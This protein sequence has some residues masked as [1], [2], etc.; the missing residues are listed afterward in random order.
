MIARRRPGDGP[1]RR[2]C[3]V[4][5][6]AG[7]L[8]VLSPLLALTASAVLVV[9]GR[10]V[11][12]RQQ[13]CGRGGGEFTILK[14]RTLRAAERPDQPDAERTTRLGAVLR[15]TGTDELPQ[16]VNVLRGEMSFIGPRPALPEH[17][18]NYDRRQTGRLAVRP[19]I[20]GW[21]QVR[22]RNALSWP[23]RIELDL[24]YI[25]RRGLLLDLRILMLTAVVVLVPRG[26]V[27]PGGV[28]RG[29]P[30]PGEDSGP[31]D[32]HRA[33]RH[34]ADLRDGWT[35]AAPGGADIARH[36]R[37]DEPAVR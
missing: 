15:A 34:R 9:L 4:F 26:V 22:G 33:G 37:D 8:L 35:P 3:D 13:R 20:T 2:V 5:G 16:L 12:F 28:N 10:P 30:A 17:V 21:A 19:G 27:G 36:R 29:M 11:S 31:R 24:D 7:L 25:R 23:E 6:A 32:P 18:G 14:F 1:V